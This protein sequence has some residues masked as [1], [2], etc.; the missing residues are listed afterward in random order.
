MEQIAVFIESMGSIRD[1][2][3]RQIQGK[4][5]ESYKDLPQMVLG[6]SGS[7]CAERRTH[8]RRCFPRPGAVPMGPTGQSIAF[9]K[10]PGMEEL[11]S[12]VTIRRASTRRMRFF[13]SS[14]DDGGRFSSSSLNIAISSS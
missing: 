10:T 11:Y 12:G 2:D 14:T 4:Q 5:V 9:F 13:S 7:D 8:D 6:P 3:L 1:D